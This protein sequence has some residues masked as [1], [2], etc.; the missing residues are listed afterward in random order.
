LK[1]STT[2]RV[3][4]ILATLGIYAIALTAVAPLLWMISASL[5]LPSEIFE[6]PVRWIPRTF[7]WQNYGIV[8]NLL[9]E[10]PRDYRFGLAYLNSAK[11]TLLAVLGS[12]TTS[13]LAGYAFAKLRFRGRDFLFMLYLSTM[14]IPQEVVLIPKFILFDKL[15]FIGT[16]W[17]IILP[18]LVTPTGTFLMRQYFLQVPDS[19]RESAKIDGAGEFTIWRSMMMPLALP[20]VASLG[21]LVFMW[22]WN[23]FLEPL[24][25][26]TR[27]RTYTIP[28]A[29]AGF[30]DENLSDYSI[31]MAAS[32]SAL[33]PMI[34]VFLAGQKYFIKG[35]TAGAVKG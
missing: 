2:G 32:V 31:I 4:R 5:K 26:L 27:S 15:G 1:A 12:V 10:A 25:F 17:P 13:S 19:I 11:V 30:I 23:N 8:W 7:R 24:V 35:L 34:L 21:V 22:N 29:L 18:Y 3:V 20:A 14:M 6:F 9:A 33:L 28:V 16:H